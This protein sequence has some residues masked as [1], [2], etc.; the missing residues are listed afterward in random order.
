MQTL[1]PELNQGVSE[2]IPILSFFTG[3]GFLDIGFMQ[4]GFQTV[5]TNEYDPQ[6]AWGFEHGI[7]SMTGE[8]FKISNT[9]SIVELG[10]N[11]IAREAFNNIQIPE[12]FGIIGGPPC[13]DF[14]VGGKNTGRDGLRG[15]LSKIYVDKIL[16]LQPTFFLFENVKGLI[17]TAK[18]KVFFDELRAQFSEQYLTE[19]KVLNSLNFGVPQD[20]ERVFMVGINKKWLKRKLGVRNIPKDYCWFYWPEDP[21]YSNAKMRFMWPQDSPFGV[22]PK[23]P[24]DIPETLMVGPLIC[25]IE[26]IASLPNGL[27]GFRPRS[28]KYTVIR[29]GDVS[30]KSFKRLHRWRYSPTVAYGNNEV[31][32]HPTQPRRLTV[33][34]ALRIQSVP[35]TF[36]LPSDMSLSHKYKT[37]GN[38]VPVK[39]ANVIALAIK[40]ML[41]EVSR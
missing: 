19:V 22:N 31:H 39:L 20:R 14:S 29:E 28:D 8:H 33:R 25:N 34:E 37:I 40:Q 32:L 11:Q 4:A 13:P 23:Q 24:F 15:R 5:W 35:D 41:L 21:R 36:I 38:G 27:E 16:D 6:F 12:I 17:R 30:R 2:R 18:H 10:P 3:A 26:E 1:S 7:S 9:A